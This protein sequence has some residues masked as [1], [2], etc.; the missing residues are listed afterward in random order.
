MDLQLTE[1]TYIIS[2]LFYL[3]ILTVSYFY[4][5][6][7]YDHTNKTYSYLNLIFFSLVILIIAGSGIRL[8]ST[9]AIKLPAAINGIFLVL[10]IIT[11]PVV[12]GFTFCFITA[13]MTKTGR[14]CIYAFILLNVINVVLVAVSFVPGTNIYLNFVNGEYVSGDFIW[15]FFIFSIRSRSFSASIPA[16]G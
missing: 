14:H 5:R 8:A 6:K 9:G 13:T 3:I 4:L 12:A 1:S 7:Q 10:S 16:A 11:L 15:L 2:T